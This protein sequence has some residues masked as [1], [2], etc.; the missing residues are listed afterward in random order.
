M[1]LARTDRIPPLDTPGSRLIDLDPVEARDLIEQIGAEYEPWFAALARYD[2]CRSIEELMNAKPGST[3]GEFQRFRSL[4]DQHAMARRAGAPEPASLRLIGCRT[5]ATY[6]P[7]SGQP[8]P[9][10][11]YFVSGVTA[12]AL[13]RSLA[14]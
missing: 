1:N 10:D 3:A 14:R 12:R 9:E 4:V 13:R 2:G 7:R 5:V 6:D 8:C 11:F